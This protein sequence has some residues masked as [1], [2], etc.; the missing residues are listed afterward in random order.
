[1]L[2]GDRIVMMWNF[3]DFVNNSVTLEGYIM[4]FLDYWT[5]YWENRN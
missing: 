5:S 1:M 3:I 2:D 4:Q